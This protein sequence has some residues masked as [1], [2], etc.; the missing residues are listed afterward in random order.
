MLS[1]LLRGWVGLVSFLAMP[2]TGMALTL[3][4][5]GTGRSDTKVFADS[6]STVLNSFFAF[7]SS[8]GGVRV[9]AGDVNGDGVAEVI[10]GTGP[11]S[12]H[13][14][15]IK[16][17]PSSIPWG[18]AAEFETTALLASFFAF[19]PTF[20]GGVFVGAG[21]VSGDNFDDIIVGTDAGSSPHVKVIDGT[22]TG[23]VLGNGQIS[24]ERTPRQ[25]FCI[26]SRLHGRRPRGRGRSQR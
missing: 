3:A 19:D 1:K 10:A 9:A 17:A 23:L 14:K 12:S 6:S 18:P 25:F 16:T 26:Q 20:T 24:D 13:V 7:E 2:T 21:H 22:K 5:V 8:T 15:V 11:G 4:G